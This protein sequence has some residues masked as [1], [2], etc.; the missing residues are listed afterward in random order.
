MIQSQL[1]L[2]IM[3]DK[4]LDFYQIYYKEE[5]R[6]YLYDF[7]IPYFNRKVTPYFENSLIKT[8]VTM[9]LHVSSR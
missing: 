1:L 7:A 5:Q 3:S 2:T 9:F 4:T 8:L 6:D